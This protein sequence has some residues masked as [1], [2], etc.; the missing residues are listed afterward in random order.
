MEL[1]NSF[2]LLSIDDE[3]SSV[4]QELVQNIP[5]DYSEGDDDY[6]NFVRLRRSKLS[7][8][9]LYLLDSYKRFTQ[10]RCECCDEPEIKKSIITDIDRDYFGKKIFLSKEI[11][12]DRENGIE[13]L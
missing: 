10:L 4:E 11:K 3:D 2:E 5:S 13:F 6:M 12:Y 1:K 8:D 9:M 7:D